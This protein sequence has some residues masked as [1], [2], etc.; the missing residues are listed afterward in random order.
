RAEADRMRT[1]IRGGW[2]VAHAD[3]QHQIVRDGVCVVEDDRIL[4]VG[5][6]YDGAVDTTIDASGKL[7]APGLISTHQHAGGVGGDYVYLDVGRPESQGRNYLNWQA[8]VRGKPRYRA[9]FRTGALFN[10]AQ[11]LRQG[12]TTVVEI[13]SAGN[14]ARFVEVVEELGSRVY[15]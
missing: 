15:T 11:A 12:T 6:R 3:G 10:L 1:L 9:D 8:G 5:K 4:H 14:P 13:G 2:V 7:V